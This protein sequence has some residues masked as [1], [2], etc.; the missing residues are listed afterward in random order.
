MTT[1][2]P[3]PDFVAGSSKQ[4]SWANDLRFKFLALAIDNFPDDDLRLFYYIRVLPTW[5]IDHRQELD[6]KNAAKHIRSAKA[7]VTKAGSIEAAIDAQL[8]SVEKKKI[9]A[10][11]YKEAQDSSVD[12]VL[13]EE[14]EA[15]RGERPW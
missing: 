8:L 11:R 9:K 6:M 14:I 3:L 15:E 7:A 1:K 2:N 10:E 4:Q 13:L 5:W 12:L